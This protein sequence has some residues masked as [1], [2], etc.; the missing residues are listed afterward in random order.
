M[1][2]PTGPA[3]EPEWKRFLRL[4][5]EL[6]QQPTAADQCRILLATLRQAF[7]GSA[8]VW[9]ARPYYP[10]PGEPEVKILPSERAPALVQ[11]A[12][13]TRAPAYRLDEQKNTVEAA[14]PLRAEDDL[15]GVLQ[16]QCPENTCMDSIQQATIEAI[17]LF[18]ALALQASRQASIKHWRHEQLSLVRSVSAQ[19]ANVTNLDE[20]SERVTQ[21]IQEKFD[22]Y[23]VGLYTLE[24][25]H[26]RFRACASLSQSQRAPDL[27]IGLGQGMTGLAAQTGEEI[28]AG[29]VRN[30]PRYRYTDA[31]PETQSEYTLPLKVENRVLGVL[32]IQ[33]DQPDAFHDIDRLVLGSLADSIALAVEGT[34][35]YHT[36]EKRAEQIQAVLAVSHALSSILDL[37][38]LLKEVVTVIHDAFDY[39]YVHIF[40]VHPGRRKI[41]YRAGSGERAEAYRERG[42]VYDLDAAEGI[43][44][45]AARTGQTLLANDVSQEAHYRPSE[46][47]PFVTNS[48]LA[49]PV[50]FNNVVL[51]VLDIQSDQPNAFDENDRGVLEALSASIAVA[52]RNANLYRSEVWRRQ[53][54][55]SFRDV[56]G[57]LSANV[58]L[59]DL[60]KRILQ[61]LESNLPCDASAIWL[62]DDGNGRSG[63]ALRLAAASGVD[64]QKIEDLRLRLPGMRE[65]LEDALG[66]SQP[67]IRKAGEKPG[68]LGAALEL[69]A[70][71]SSIT[72]PLL[73]SGKPLGL[74]TL[75]HHTPGRYGSEAQDMVET[76]S[77]YAA[78]A[79]QN[80]RLFGE[81]Q[82]QAW[83]STVLLQVAE[84]NQTVV[85]LEELLT[86][87]IRLIPLLLGVTQAAIYLW[88]EGQQ[89][90]RVEETYGLEQPEKG[91]YFS[92]MD[93]SALARLK[94]TGATLFIQNPAEELNLPNLTLP[95]ETGTLV[96][97]PL[98]SRSEVIGAL[99]VG[100]QSS[101]ILGA[102]QQFNE[103]MLAILQGIAHQTAMSIE[104]M[105]LVE[106]RQEEAYVT[107]VLLQVAQAVVTLNNLDDI[108]DTIVHLMPILVGID[109][110]IV[111]TWDQNRKL[112]L[113]SKAF[114]GIREEERELLLR[115]Y[116]PG[117]FEL[118]DHVREHDT[119]ILCPLSDTDLSPSLW[120]ELPCLPP[121]S[122]PTP[123]MSALGS[124]LMGVP[125]TVKGV[126]YGVLLAKENSQQPG[127]RNKRLEIINGVAQEVALAIQNQH[128]QNEMVVRERMEREVQLARE[129]QRTFLP[130]RLPDPQGWE[131]DARWQTARQVGGDFYDL[132]PLSDQ[133]LGIVIADVADKGMPA[134]LYMTVTRTLIRAS[135]HHIHSPARVLERVNNLLVP[136]AQNGMFVTALY[137]VLSLKTGELTYASAGHNRPFRIL[138]GSGVEQLRKGG[139]ALGVME[140]NPLEDQKLQL[141]PGDSLLFYTDGVTDTFAPDGSAF[142]EERLRDVLSCCPDRSA[143]EVLNA[144][145]R[146]LAAFRQDEPLSDDITMLAVR[147]KEV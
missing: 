6:L 4:A 79:I 65:W 97:L 57:L 141:E 64:G 25:S 35:L 32:D 54:A 134:A 140:N 91:A 69:P 48:E 125:L 120:P 112:F 137:A 5:E 136:D 92:E 70:D 3:A 28:L 55:D 66:A 130:D 93:I 117:E 142:G 63:R 38:Q 31:L 41:F 78:V 46:L 132:F 98:L 60:L 118:L 82:E 122:M 106:A 27:L 44:P 116:G 52:M 99:L 73:S 144:V 21:L 16:F 71:Y 133:R 37:D 49:I 135:V 22:Y 61:A 1:T 17:A 10:L 95:E 87:T 105:R 126:T 15:L 100:H 88:D 86:N 77:S 67:F 13:E 83:I 89:A 53:V 47:P 43:I 11:T 113:P 110:C 30:E 124:W 7:P 90:Y 34:R 111:Y 40:T 59:E 20:L 123:A 45:Y 119:F 23:Y 145:D 39:P 42:L 102:E 24:N 36:V 56:A 18:S 84:A 12:F 72:S 68:P 143:Q 101:G 129:I 146:A 147:R 26:L 33:S 8:D 80:A 131:L 107:A 103:Q 51:A 62:L 128:L 115:S 29:D 108:L 81:S 9:L 50:L 127:F 104:N 94:A 139:M 121:G 114:S 2:F 138:A 14:Y 74:L 109:A 96:L 76:F 19:I 85:T 75:A 58:E